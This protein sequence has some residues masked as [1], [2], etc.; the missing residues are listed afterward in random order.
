MCGR[1]ND[2]V[3]PP[4]KL[5]VL[6]AVRIPGSDD[7]NSFTTGAQLMIA[8]HLKDIGFGFVEVKATKYFQCVV[9]LVLE[10]QVGQGN[11]YIKALLG[12]PVRMAKD[13]YPASLA[14]FIE[15]PQAGGERI[16]VGPV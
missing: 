11:R 14:D 6:T 13:A 12:V 1:E 3:I 4:E 16:T 7:G 5:A 15:S 8:R 2:G 10:E 9:R